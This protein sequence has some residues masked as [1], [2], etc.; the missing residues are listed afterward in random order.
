MNK[1]EAIEKIE[2]SK[3]S[4]FIYDFD[5]WKE[6]KKFNSGLDCALSY[7]KQLDEPEKP[8]VPRCVADMIVKRKRAGQS[9]VKAIENLRFYEDACKWV[10][11][12]G[13]TFV[14]AWLYGYEV[15]KVKYYEVYQKRNGAQ[16]GVC[17]PDGED[18][19]QFT[20]EELKEF[21]LDSLDAYEVKEVEE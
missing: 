3:Y 6:E 21:E 19:T 18:K 16:L 5:G 1:Q 7:V 12:N 13:E 17:I 9:V 20:A 10:R 2:A 14:K 4:E 11:N 15:D 8:V